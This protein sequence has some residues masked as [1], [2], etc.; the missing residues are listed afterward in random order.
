MT[1]TTKPGTPP[2]TEVS[3][4]D[5]KK[6]VP[7]NGVQGVTDSEIKVAVITAGSNPLAG[8]YTTFHD[9]IQAYF[10]M[11]NARAASTAASW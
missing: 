3:G 11:I 4:A 8:D 2:I 7:L 9:G 5:L 1:P 6:N 10:D